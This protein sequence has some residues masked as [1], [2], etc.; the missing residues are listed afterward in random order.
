MRLIRPAEATSERRWAVAM[1]L[2]MVLVG[3]VAV[4]LMG[5]LPE[6]RVSGVAAL[7]IAAALAIG[8]GL[9][10]LIRAL[11]MGRAREPGDDLAAA[12]GPAFDD[13]YVLV[14]SPRLP[15][16]PADL[17]ALLIGPAGV[18]A[19]I[20]RRWPG[21]YRVRGRGWEYDTKSRSGW[22]PC[23]TNP[24][25]DAHAVADAVSAWTRTALDDGGVPVVPA[26][27]FPRRSSVIVME[28]PDIEILT[29]DNAPWWAQRIGRVQRLEPARVARLVRA[30]LDAGEAQHPSVPAHAGSRPG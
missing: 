8:I 5:L 15:G 10:W 28:E 12:L 2:G 29:A 3:G 19:L 24:S 4:V 1:S 14:L 6:D 22:I 21:R 25:F 7:G 23:R 13:S 18:R 26:V 20:A 16:V 27:A 30:V 11:G 9:A 17:A